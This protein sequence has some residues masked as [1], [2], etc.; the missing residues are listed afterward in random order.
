M[1]NF[2]PTVTRARTGLVLETNSVIRNTYILLS[3]TLLFSALAAWWSMTTNAAPM[4]FGVLLGYF[5]L[6][7]LTQ[8]LRNSAWGIASIFA[9]T[10]FM[11]YTLGPLLNM[12]M[13]SYTNGAELVMTAFGLTGIIF[14]ALSAYALTTRKDFSYLMGFLFAGGMVAFIA[15]LAAVFLQLPL[16]SLMGSAAFVLISSGYILFQTSQII[17][18]GERNY[19]MATI[20]LYVSIYNIFVSLLQILSIFGGRRD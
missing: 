16:L 15:S 9:L 12:V 4:G 18:G 3:S 6:L 17:N 20:T 7:F 5:G 14:L 13:Y 1:K 11:G 8:T 19:I 10:G 2:T